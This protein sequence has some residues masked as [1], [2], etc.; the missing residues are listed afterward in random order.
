MKEKFIVV[1]LYVDDRTVLSADRQQTYTT[2]NGQKKQ[3]RTIGDQWA[4]FQSENFEA[5]AQPQYAIINGD[6]KLLTRTKSYTP[7][8]QE[9]KSW[10]ECGLKA[11]EEK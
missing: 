9:F 6:E 5:V 11:F 1:S 8:A 3:I 10:L 7:D 2:R 4:T